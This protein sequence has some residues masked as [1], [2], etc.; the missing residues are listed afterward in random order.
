L[1]LASTQRE[2][3]RNNWEDS[4]KGEEGTESRLPIEIQLAWYKQE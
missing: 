4:N 3:A 2:E 1:A